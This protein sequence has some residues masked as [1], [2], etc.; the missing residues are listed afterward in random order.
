MTSAEVFEAPEALLNGLVQ[1]TIE[2][3]GDAPP[4]A[5]QWLDDL[6]SKVDTY[7]DA[8]LIVLAYAVEAGSTADVAKPPA[9]RRTVAQ[10]LADALKD[11]NIRCREDAFQTLAKGT[12]SLLG[13]KRGSWNA[14]LEWAERQGSIEPV[15]QALR[16]MASGIARTGVVAAE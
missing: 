13:R 4:E 8:A 10:R 6:L 2:P 15:E 12:S 7:R 9:G 1:G 3:E 16:Y 11:M 5:R 14:L